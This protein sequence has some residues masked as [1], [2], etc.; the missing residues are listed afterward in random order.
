M[1]THAL[2]L[3]IYR[4]IKYDYTVVASTSDYQSDDDDYVRISKFVDVDFPEANH[5]E[6]QERQIQALCARR[7]NVEADMQER[8]DAIDRQIEELRALPAPKAA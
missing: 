4:N 6:V 7:D 2:T 5:A 3:A 1:S 8:L